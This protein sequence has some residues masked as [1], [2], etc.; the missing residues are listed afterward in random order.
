MTAEREEG[1]GGERRPGP[2]GRATT[3]RD[4]PW[5]SLLFFPGTR[6]DR[7][8]KALAS[9]ADLVCADL[10]DAVGPG[11]KDSA[12]EHVAGL[13]VGPE[14]V[15]ARSAIRVNPAASDEGRRDLEVLLRAS[16][17]TADAPPLI[18][19]LPKVSEAGVVGDVVARFGDAGQDVRIVAMIET[20]VG[21]EHAVAL[22]RA[23]GVVALF[24]GAVDLASDLGCALDW[25]ALLYARSR[26]V[27]ASAMGRV[28]SIDVPFLALQ[29]EVGLDDE[30]RAVARLG[31]TGKAAIHPG[32]IATIHAALA[33]TRAELD[34]ARGILEA[35]ERAAGGVSVFEGRMIDRPVVEAA[36]R[37][38]NRGER[39][40]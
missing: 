17:R 11:D 30:T 6:P 23:P 38:I 21:V 3:G 34:R 20:A 40:R 5:R 32:Q 24:L 36:R 16:S 25:D 9:G 26:V 33:P 1:R 7:Y 10:E 15:A 28:Q 12:R 14:W 8:A 31:F 13:L 35:H 39:S 2:S 4:D 37:T 19:V 27:H 29:D 22:A 18:L